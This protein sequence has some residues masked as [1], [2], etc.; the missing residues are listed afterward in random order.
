[1]EKLWEH[2]DSPGRTLVLH[3]RRLYDRRYDPRFTAQCA[4]M[5]MVT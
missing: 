3:M 4:G 1:M 2:G 5:T